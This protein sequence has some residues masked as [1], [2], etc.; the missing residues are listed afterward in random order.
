MT[1][2]QPSALTSCYMVER[3]VPDKKAMAA[4]LLPIL[5]ET[6]ATLN[7]LD[8]LQISEA[9]NEKGEE[10]SPMCCDKEELK[11]ICGVCLTGA[12]WFAIRKLS[13]TDMLTPAQAGAFRLANAFVTDIIKTEPHASATDAEVNNSQPHWWNDSPD[14]VTGHSQVQ[15]ML[16][17]AIET[18]QKEDLMPPLPRPQRLQRQR[19]RHPARSWRR[20]PRNYT[21]RSRPR[22]IRNLA[23]RLGD[24]ER[25]APTHALRRLPDHQETGTPLHAGIGTH[26]R[27]PAQ[28]HTQRRQAHARSHEHAK[29]RRPEDHLPRPPTDTGGPRRNSRRPKVKETA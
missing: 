9:E 12:I 24:E 2:Y 7:R 20:L 8:W 29:P 4:L 23:Q 16:T 21:N 5:N 25:P 14:P 18:L 11:T 22:T 3:Q 1:E 6:Q 28:S 10:M 17:A 27:R 15:H 19:Q 13:G 26:S